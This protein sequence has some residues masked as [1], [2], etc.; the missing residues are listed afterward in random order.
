M[1]EKSYGYRIVKVMEW[2]N[3]FWKGNKIKNMIIFYDEVYL[4]YVFKSGN[5]YV[6]GR[7]VVLL[8]LGFCYCESSLK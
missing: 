7:R 1:S 4:R 8:N 2:N 6:G 3:L 5:S